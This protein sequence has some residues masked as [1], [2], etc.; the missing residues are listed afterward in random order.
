M[1]LPASGHSGGK[2]EEREEKESWVKG[3]GRRWRRME[4]EGE[5]GVGDERE[6]RGRLAEEGGVKSP[7]LFS[8]FTVMTLAWIRAQL[9]NDK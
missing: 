1:K 5:K 2:E 7:R 9:L 4:V 3:E 6:E 8:T